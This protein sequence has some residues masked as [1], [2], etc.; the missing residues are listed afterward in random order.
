MRR[1]LLTVLC[2]VALTATAASLEAQVTEWS[3]E[4][5]VVASFKVNDAAAQALLPAGWVLDPSTAPASRG[6]NLNI[7]VM[8]RKVV[9]DPQGRPLKTGTSRY[10]VVG[11]P[12][13]Q[14]ASGQTNTVV[15]Y[16]I[17]PEGP[18]A[19]DVYDFATVARVERNETGEGEAQGKARELWSFAAAGGDRLSLTLAYQRAAATRSRSEVHVRSGK[20][21][22]YT[23]TYKIEQAA[24]V[25]RS[26]ASGVNRVETW[27]FSA[28]GPHLGPLFNGSE[29]LV[30]LTVVPSY[31]R[32]ISLP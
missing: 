15:V 7:T 10:L 32:E 29:A 27:T 12:A 31:I 26:T 21:P 23:R 3:A 1:L 25:V 11:I 6:A 24:D 8:E 28:S 9:L 18:G 17:S 5:R 16:G 20:H 22:E 30:S 13:R 2:A 14:T 4:T 19:Y